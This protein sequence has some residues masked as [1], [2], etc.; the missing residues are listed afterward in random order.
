[1]CN[2]A[3]DSYDMFYGIFNLLYQKLF[4]RKTIRVNR[5][6]EISSHISP[7]LN[8]NIRE[9][10]RLKRLASK[11]IHIHSETYRVYRNKKTNILIDA[12]YSYNKQQLTST[13]G[14]FKSHW[15]TINSILGRTSTKRTVIQIEL[16][17]HRDDISSNCSNYFYI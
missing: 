13:Q 17:P 1:M 10:D 3:N 7:A 14:D 16:D 11:W 12:K 5:K 9:R 2:D 6:K 15:K 8:T 4:S